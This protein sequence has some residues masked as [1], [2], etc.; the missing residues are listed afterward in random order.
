MSPLETVARLVPLIAGLLLPG[1]AI[2]RALRLPA[3]VSV[4]FAG[5]TVVLYGTVLAYT[6]LGIPISLGSLA[7]ALTAT[8]AVAFGL[9][10]RHREVPT[11]EPTAGEAGWFTPFRG[12][13]RWTPLYLV[14]WAIVVY[15]VC[16]HPLIG[17]DIEF[18]WS[19]LAEQMLRHGSLDFYPPRQAA[20]FPVYF[21]AESIPPG[22]ASQQAW[23]FACGGSASPMWGAPAVLLQFWAVHDLLWRL[24]HFLAG[25]T[26]AHAACLAAAA[27]PLL[28]WSILLGQETGFTTLALLGLVYALGRSRAEPGMAWAVLAGIFAALGASAREYGVVFPVFGLLGLVGMRSSRRNISLFLVT[29]VPLCAAWLAR[30][31]VLTGN[32]FYSLAGALFPTNE[33]FSLWRQHDRELYGFPLGT[34]DAWWEILRLITVLAPTA[35]LGWLALAIQREFRH[36][37]LWS[38]AALFLGLWW[39]S[40]PY[41]SGGLFYS[42]RVASPAFALGVLGAGMMIARLPTR[43]GGPALAALVIASLPQTLTL[44]EN[45]WRLPIHEWMQAIPDRPDPGVPDPQ[46]DRI[47]ATVGER[48]RLIAEAPGFQRRLAPHGIA[49]VPPWS[50]QA[51]WLF[52][53][54]LPAAEAVRRWHREGIRHILLAKFAPGL[55]FINAQARW[56]RPPFGFRIAWEDEAW[57]LLEIELRDPVS[58]Q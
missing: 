5:S 6:I 30:C 1:A 47:A 33:L 41:T 25:R 9:S 34:T 23:A 29:G 28:N 12:L 4:A 46:L 52:E 55:P 45:A 31:V 39:V 51:A 8:T 32:P 37:L 40:V 58:F 10:R 27:C 18:R 14:F 38:G 24:A 26:A 17:P 42:M 13:G 3:S 21:W 36:A 50:P 19:W 16:Q 43:V 22:V 49:V 2:A 53:P 20:D 7:A 56:T 48:G 15:R 54:Q 11:I 44:P 35:L 57:L